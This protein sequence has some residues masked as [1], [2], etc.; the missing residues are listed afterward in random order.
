AN[1]CEGTGL[2][3]FC[4]A[5]CTP[6]VARGSARAPKGQSVAKLLDAVAPLL[7]KHGGHAAAAGFEFDPVNA[8]Q[9]AEALNQ[10]ASTSSVSSKPQLDIDLEV[11]P[12]ELSANLLK[13]ISELEPFG[14]KFAEPVYMCSRVKLASEPRI[15]GQNQNV[16]Q[17]TFE[18]DGTIEKG[19][20]FKLQEQHKQLRA[21]DVIDVAFTASLNHFRGRS[22]PQWI[23]RDFR[24]ST[25]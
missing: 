23:L 17:F 5:E 20:V 7:S 8:Q 22:T 19:I 21:G 3:T 11:S 25:D 9:I 1:I 13:R 24:R 10:A 18:R 6:G 16:M 4:W 14:Q 15:V 2:A 12:G